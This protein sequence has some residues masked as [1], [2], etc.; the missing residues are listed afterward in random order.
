MEHDEAVILGIVRCYELCELH[1]VIGGD[2]RGVE[3]RA[4]LYALDVTAEVS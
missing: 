1:P 4:K 3:G 2:S